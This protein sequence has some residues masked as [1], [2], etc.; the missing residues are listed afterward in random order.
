MDICSIATVDKQLLA[1]RVGSDLAKRHRKKRYYSVEEVKAAA[2]RHC[3][4]EL[5]DCWALSFYTSNNDFVDHHIATG[6]ICDY[7]VMHTKMVDA[8]TTDAAI[9]DLSN[10]SGLGLGLP[11]LLDQSS[12]PVDFPAST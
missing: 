8:V 6:E 9:P 7:A 5:W 11:D 4:P 3:I 2:R 12:R 10:H 1:R